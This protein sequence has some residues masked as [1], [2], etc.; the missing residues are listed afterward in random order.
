MRWANSGNWSGLPLRTM[1]DGVIET[2]MF[3]LWS[4]F[5][6]FA[7]VYGSTWGIPVSGCTAAQTRKKMISVKAMSAVAQSGGSVSI[8]PRLSFTVLLG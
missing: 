6:V 5:S 3:W 2:S 7:S 8:L 1:L 4:R